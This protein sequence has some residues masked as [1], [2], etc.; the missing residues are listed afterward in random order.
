MNGFLER[1]SDKITGML[2]G[3]DRIVFR[4]YLKYLAYTA[5]FEAFLVCQ[6]VLFKEFSKYVQTTTERLKEASLQSANELQR[7]IRYINSPQISKEEEARRILA[8]DPVENGL[9]CVLS[10][11]EP[12][13][14]YE[15]HRSRR[16]KR[17][18][19]KRTMR[20]CLHLYHYYLDSR[21][22]FLS[23]RIQ[24]WF[25]F[26]LQICLNGREWLSR[27]MDRAG[28]DYRRRDNC[29]TWIKDIGKA[30]RLMSRQLSSA[31]SPLLN[32]IARHLNPAHNEIFRRNRQSY[33]WCLH[34][35]EWA[36]DVMFKSSS[37][38][39]GIYP[40]LTRHA[41][42]N[43]SSPDVMRFLGQKV[44][45]AFKGE[46][47][48]DFKDRPEGIRVKHRVKGNSVKMYD[49]QGSILRIETTLNSPK[50]LK[51]YRPK[52]GKGDEELAWQ[53]LRKGV[54]DIQRRAKLSQ[55]SNERYLD[56]L[57]T[58]SNSITVAVLVKDIC[59][60]THWSGKRVR[61]LQPWSEKDASLLSAVSQG[62]F[63]VTGFRNRD[64]TQVL[65][66]SCPRSPRERRRRSGAT[67][68][69]L[70]ILRAHRIIK[71]IPKTHRYQVTKRGRLIST[72]I[73]A[74]RS[75]SVAR[76]SEAA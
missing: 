40:A 10:S 1:H 29:F 58:A 41:I 76:L 54:A 50:D 20:K 17:L 18:V 13:M 48:S 53:P 72:A 75:A 68:R 19:L 5:G 46:I 27:Q 45:H 47:I 64:I 34:Q 73:L 59:R 71:R 23:A 66:P 51:V 4:G 3:F 14:A 15:L 2:S 62:Q 26:N 60:H 67:T 63:V 32:R 21:L 42:T 22:G 24:T 70:R 69:L 33:Y 11:V 6:G 7:P 65:T 52:K 35:S 30:Q 25:P 28:L 8:K 57:A 36:T 49:K 74:A 44:H 39:A 38:L 61:A 43:L 9:I 37:V 56:S 16:L 31:W 12:C 55:D